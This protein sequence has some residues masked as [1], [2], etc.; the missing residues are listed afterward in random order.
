MTYSHLVSL[1]S[2]FASGPGIEPIA[3]KAAGRSAQNYPSLLA[4]SLGAQLTDRTASGAKLANIVDRPQRFGLKKLAPQLLHI[5]READLVTITAGGNDLGYIGSM[6]RIALASRLQ[7]NFWGKP[8]AALLRP[9]SLP[10]VTKDQRSAVVK[11]L[12]RVF[13]AVRR[14]MPA[15]RIVLVDYLT[16]LDARSINPVDAPFT[17]AELAALSGLAHTLSDVFQ[18]VSRQ[19]GVDFISLRSISAD[20]VVGSPEPWV[21]GMPNGLRSIASRPPF[22]PN[23]AGMRAVAAQIHQVVTEASSPGKVE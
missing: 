14:Q 2:S 8:A 11:G 16:V 1:G 18:E 12:M 21:R 13:E 17:Q 5:P 23:V 15:A 19:S 9:N 6:I 22:H 20:H 3:D 7:S 4:S 10:A